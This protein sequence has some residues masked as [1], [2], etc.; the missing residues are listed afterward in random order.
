MQMASRDKP[1]WRSR[2]WMPLFSLALGAAI[3]AAFA[4]GGDAGQG[5]LSFAV[6]AAV[7]ALFYFGGRSETLRGLGGPGR[8]ERWAAIDLRASAVA[9]FV[10]ITVVL[11]AWLWE[12]A[13]GD[14]GSPYVQVA[15][16]AGVAYI[17]AVAFL[18]LRS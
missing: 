1:F 10:L 14:D 11:G 6:M 9:G 12:V 16:V 3:F 7:A 5:A 8:D 17:A 2:W 13:N 15:A 4:I 18:R